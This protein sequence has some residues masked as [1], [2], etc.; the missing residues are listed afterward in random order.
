M[1]QFYDQYGSAAE[2][3]GL[4][5]LPDASVQI[6]PDVTASLPTS[7]PSSV[8]DIASSIPSVEPV[9]ERV[10]AGLEKARELIAEYT[11]PFLSG[12]VG[13]PTPAD[14]TLD[15]D[16]TLVTTT[17]RGAGGSTVL[18]LAL[19]LGAGTGAA[20]Y[21]LGPEKT[22]ELAEQ[23]LV[24]A[25]AWTKMAMTWT[26]VKMRRALKWADAQAASL[27]VKVYLDAVGAHLSALAVHLNAILSHP[28]VI[29]A[30][31]ATVQFVT[32]TALPAAQLALQTCA[33]HVKLAYVFVKPHVLTG[34]E[35]AKPHMAAAQK[36][37][38]ELISMII[39]YF[40]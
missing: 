20:V 8:E 40:K 25:K 23:S 14:T 22:K 4:P 39:A 19:L 38:Q 36:A 6:A 17:A 15:S 3:Y 10:T 27:G 34:I 35:M 2:A 37:V 30:Q 12:G 9:M 1:A 18:S 28:H 26:D 11:A 33:T 29:A 31:T 24:K 13:T 21:Y 5:A 16:G 7:L 32:K